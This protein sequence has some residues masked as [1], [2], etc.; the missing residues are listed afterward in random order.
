[1]NLG[2]RGEVE[3]VTGCGQR[4]R[5][6]Q[7]RR[8]F[9]FALPALLQLMLLV[10]VLYAHIVTIAAGEKSG[11]VGSLLKHYVSRIFL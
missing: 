1:M 4:H 3:S 10:R 6:E 2:V 9:A 8:S 11:Q 5:H 7:R